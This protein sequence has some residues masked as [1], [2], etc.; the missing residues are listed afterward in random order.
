[1]AGLSSSGAPLVVVGSGADMEVC[2]I[3]RPLEEGVAAD[4]MSEPCSC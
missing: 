1:M 2:T 4:G 3:E